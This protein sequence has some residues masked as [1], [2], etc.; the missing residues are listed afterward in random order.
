MQAYVSVI[1]IG[2]CPVMSCEYSYEKDN[3]IQTTVYMIEYLNVLGYRYNIN[4]RHL[5]INMVA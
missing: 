1:R 4:S 2:M 5:V 3:K